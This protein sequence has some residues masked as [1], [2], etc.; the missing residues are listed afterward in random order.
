MKDKTVAV[1]YILKDHPMPDPDS[2]YTFYVLHFYVTL[3][4]TI[5]IHFQRWHRLTLSKNRLICFPVSCANKKNLDDR[6]LRINKDREIELKR[7]RERDFIRDRIVI[8]IYYLP[9]SPI[10]GFLNMYMLWTTLGS[11]KSKSLSQ[12]F[13]ILSQKVYF[14]KTGWSQWRAWPT[15][16]RECFGSTNNLPFLS[17]APDSKKHLI[18]SPLS[19]KYLFLTWNVRKKKS[20]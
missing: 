2:W 1:R 6:E 12:R 4:Q 9:S 8:Y 15:L 5:N 17:R 11:S 16:L 7:D 18:L 14:L 13:F 20:L 3:E 10:F 19:S